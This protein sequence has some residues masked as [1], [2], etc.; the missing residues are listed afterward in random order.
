MHRITID[1][2][3]KIRCCNKQ[4]SLIRTSTRTTIDATTRSCSCSPIRSTK[5]ASPTTKSTTFAYSPT[6]A[7][8]MSC[9]VR[10][11]LSTSICFLI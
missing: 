2:S 11:R 10:S 8:G 5:P 1:I 4:A 7:F 3:I 9:R 6:S